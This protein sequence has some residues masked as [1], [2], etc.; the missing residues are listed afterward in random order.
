M[1]TSIA[2]ASNG[3]R[4]ASITTDVTFLVVLAFI[5]FCLLDPVTA[6]RCAFATSIL[7]Q[8]VCQSDSCGF[9]GLC[10]PICRPW[11]TTRPGPGR[12]EG[13][14]LDHER[15]VFLGITCCRPQA[16]SL[17]P[18][19]A[20][21]EKRLERIAQA[22][23]YEPLVT[24]ARLWLSA[25]LHA[26]LGIFLEE[27]ADVDGK[28]LQLLVK[29]LSRSKPQRFTRFRYVAIVTSQSLGDYTALVTLE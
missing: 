9:L 8:P 28:P 25:I 7:L 18:P 17:K 24:Y 27:V 23:R 20:A 19:K 14:S 11:L 21:K 12:W 3:E 22:F 6:R 1:L 26:R 29:R 2:S 5:R 10:G 15:W 13:P 16:T 4:I